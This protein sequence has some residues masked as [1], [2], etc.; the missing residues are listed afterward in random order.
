M[1]IS[2][3]ILILA[4]AVILALSLAALGLAALGR[5]GNVTVYVTVDAKAY[6]S[7]SIYQDQ[8]VV[9]APQDGSWHNTLQIRNGRAAI[10]EADCENQI[11]VHTPALSPDLVG[12]IAC[13]PHGMVVELR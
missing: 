2:N 7:Y 6:G 3:R 13:L 9:I 10:I 5:A 1:R 8:T 4:V 11:C 12:V